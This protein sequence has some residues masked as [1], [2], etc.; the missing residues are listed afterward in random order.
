MDILKLVKEH[1]G[2]EDYN[3][4]QHKAIAAGAIE[5]SIVVSSP[6][7]SGKTILAEIAAL[8]SIL[9][10]GK[11]AVYTCPLRALASEHAK[12]FKAKYSAPLSIKSVISTGDLDSGGVNLAGKDAIFTT[13]E[14]LASL[15]THRA[16]W[17][18]SIGVL[19]IDEVHSLGTDRGPTLEMLI[20]K[21]R[22]INPQL[23]ILGLSA[24]IPNAKEIAS[25]LG[26]QLVVSDYRPVKLREGVY[27]DGVIDFQNDAIEVEKHKDEVSSLC[28]DTL[29]KGKQALVFVNTRRTSESTA[30]KLALLT[31][32]LLSQK[33]KL[34]L[35]KAAQKIL[36]VL[37]TPTEQCHTLA[38]LVKSGVSFHNAGLLY[39]QRE[40][41]EGLFK[42]NYIK[43][44]SATPTLCV[45]PETNLWQGTID[46]QANSFS[47]KQKILALK[48][49]NLNEITP[50]E[51]QK[52]ENTKNIMHLESVAGYSIK[53][54]SNHK[55]LV[56]RNGKKLLIPAEEC[57][58]G[59]RIA[60]V[61]KIPRC[62]S[63]PRYGINKLDY[64]GADFFYFAGC[65]LGDGYSGAETI[66]GSMKLKGS[67]CIVG[68]DEEVFN[69]SKS[70]SACMGLQYRERQNVYGVPSL[71]LSKERWLRELLISC[72]V[73]KGEH[74]FISD[75]LKSAS[76]QNIAPLIQGLFDTDGCVSR[77]RD[78]SFSNISILLIKDLQ[79]LLLI[80]GIVARIRK[81]K[82]RPIQMDSKS[83]ETKDHYELII[84]QKESILAF[85]QHIGFRIQRKQAALEEVATAIQRN[86]RHIFCP[87]C[88]YLLFK[89]LFCGRTKSHETWGAKKLAIIQCLGKEGCLSSKV[90]EKK[91]GF[92][93]Y[94]KMR[95]LNHHFE[96]LKRTRVGNEKFWEL[97]PIGH[98]IYELT[99]NN[100]TNLLL[101]LLFF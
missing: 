57:K 24:T 26:A 79:R 27:L 38:G 84:A 78:L 93:P 58:K 30:K 44:I 23:Q 11:K 14:K 25:W 66:K 91:L 62:N 6:T 45:V 97:N 96:L 22:F 19:I 39:R 7:A 9:N 37:E 1:N 85:R 95:R 76:R 13:Y 67:P 36:K 53:L 65:M 33:E 20:T 89:D 56:K 18:S 61:G 47:D 52:V 55:V 82:G 17:L 99:K 3:P 8:N 86:I 87:V 28:L 4:M 59:D 46:Y 35:E 34:A 101:F 72:G 74:K 73:E 32:P 70:V 68:R 98:Y 50:L 71:F 21:L 83:Y 100:F 69:Y 77:F 51:V 64:L 88:G 42:E 94:K 41:I 54:T 43:F 63:E 31:A 15:I 29:R 12:D 81:R 75:S 49:D 60:T 5:K 16:S 2:F 92:P 80:F 90:L 40:I 10:R 48:G